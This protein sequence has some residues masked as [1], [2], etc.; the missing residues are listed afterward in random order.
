[1]TDPPPNS[2]Y[3]FDEKVRDYLERIG[4]H[5]FLNESSGLYEPHPRRAP[6]RDSGADRHDALLQVNVQRDRWAIGIPAILSFLTLLLLIATVVY[7][8]RQWLETNRSAN[9]SE[10]AGN[11]A[12]SAAVTANSTLNEMKAESQKAFNAN[13]DAMKLDQRAWLGMSQLKINHL[14][15]GTL[16][17]E[18]SASNSGKT[19]ALKVQAVMGV[20]TEEGLYTPDERDFRFITYIVEKAWNREIKPTK[21]LSDA[22]HRVDPNYHGIL[23]PPSTFR[24]QV[25]VPQLKS[26]GVIPPGNTPYKLPLPPTAVNAGIVTTFI[27]YGEIRYFDSVNP[28]RHTTQFCYYQRPESRRDSQAI[29]YYPCD[30]FNDMN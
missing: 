12:Q 10:T 30:K 2:R 5:Y 21:V 23:P 25:F 18:G 28:K 22:F 15:D 24:A 17:Q 1:M 26:L 13:K 14:A 6:Q 16:E 8:R 9:G 7:T 20:Y 29:N 3:Q 4:H 19:P 11:A 27:F